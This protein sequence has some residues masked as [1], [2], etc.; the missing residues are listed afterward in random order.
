MCLP[1]LPEN[2]YIYIQFYKGFQLQSGSYWKIC[3]QLKD[4]QWEYFAENQKIDSSSK[5]SFIIV[6]AKKRKVKNNTISTN[7]QQNLF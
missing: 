2:I 4:V 5:N 1:H 3:I 6:V 7:T